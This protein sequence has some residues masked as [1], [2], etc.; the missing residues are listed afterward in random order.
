MTATASTSS[1]T[2]SARPPSQ[3]HWSPSFGQ[4]DGAGPSSTSPRIPPCPVLLQP[5][6]SSSSLTREG[7]AQSE[8]ELDRQTRQIE[9]ERLLAEALQEQEWEIERQA[10]RSE[11]GTWSRRAE[12]GKGK[13]TE[14]TKGFERPPQAWELYKAIDGHDID[15]IMRVRD[16][17]FGLLLQKNGGEFPI[18]YAARQG[19]KHRDVVILL[20]GALSR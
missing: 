18:V 2:S 8:L 20:V 15:Y 13:G 3:S 9:R 5:L 19:E 10:V 17:A 4:L 1:A 7:I 6:P 16:H 14:C 12:K 11:L